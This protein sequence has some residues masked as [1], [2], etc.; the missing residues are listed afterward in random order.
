MGVQGDVDVSD[1]I[2]VGEDEVFG[3]QGI[4]IG[5]GDGKGPSFM[6][7]H[8]RINDEQSKLLTRGVHVAT[9]PSSSFPFRFF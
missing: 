8:L 1:I 6:E 4:S 3:P 2:E 7:I 5:P 9:S